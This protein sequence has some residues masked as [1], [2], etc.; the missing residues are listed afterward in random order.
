MP[1]VASEFD[2]CA[3]DDLQERLDLEQDRR[4]RSSRRHVAVNVNGVSEAFLRS[5]AASDLFLALERTDHLVT[6]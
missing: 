3:R 5:A 4:V 2:S 6:A 1:C